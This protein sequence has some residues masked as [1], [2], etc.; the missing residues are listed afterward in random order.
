MQ[1][2][3]SRIDKVLNQRL[4]HQDELNQL[5]TTFDIVLALLTNLLR[6]K[7]QDID[8]D[9]RTSTLIEELSEYL[10]RLEIIE[11][12]LTR[13]DLSGHIIVAIDL[14]CQEIVLASLTSFESMSSIIDLATHLIHMMQLQN[15]RQA[16]T[17][18]M[19][20]NDSSSRA[21]IITNDNRSQS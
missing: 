11:M 13:N 16:S 10:A 1:I 9:D 21:Y 14:D 8:I 17:P 19:F 15:S 6:S 3:I 5:Y 7:S 12:R 2:S 4:E 18:T 20:V